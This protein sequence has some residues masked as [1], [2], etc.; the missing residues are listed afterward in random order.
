VTFQADHKLLVGGGS[1]QSP[2]NYVPVVPLIARL[3]RDGTLDSSFASGGIFR[4]RAAVD[5]PV[6]QVAFSKGGEIVAMTEFLRVLR[7]TSNGKLEDAYAPAGFNLSMLQVPRDA[8]FDAEGRILVAAQAVDNGL[9]AGIRRVLDHPRAQVK[10]TGTKDDDKLSVTLEQIS[11]VRTVV[12]NRNGR[13]SR[14]KA[15]EVTGVVVDAGDGDDRVFIGDGIMATVHGG[16][17][18]D[19]LEGGRGAQVFFGDGGDDQILAG[20][21]ND[22]LYGGVGNDVLD[23]GG[24][25]DYIDAGKGNDVISAQNGQ[26]DTLFGGG[27]VDSAQVDKNVDLLDGVETVA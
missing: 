1:F 23:C 17:G 9:F 21:G 13:Q 10:V 12:V 2:R 26:A 4:G 5:Y 7:L 25:N 15:V 18:N 11:G 27:G 19:R 14:F 6:E 8:A 16:A 20:P 22:S 24:G 3:N